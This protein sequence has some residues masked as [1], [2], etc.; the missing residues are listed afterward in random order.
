MGITNGQLRFSSPSNLSIVRIEQI[1]RRETE[2][3]RLIANENTTKEI[4]D[5]LYISE[6]TAE[7]HRKSLIRKLKVRNAAGL[8]RRGFELGIL[9]V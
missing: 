4:A 9:T 6:H 7:S 3:L 8:V 1:S 5:R 2:V